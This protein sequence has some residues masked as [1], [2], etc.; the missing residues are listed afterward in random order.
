M[1]KMLLVGCNGRM[2][3]VITELAAG[4]ADIEITAGVDVAGEC[5]GKYPVVSSFDEVAADVDVIVDFSS[6][7][8]FDKMLDYALGKKLPVVICTTGLSET[9]IARLDEA[10]KEIAVLRSA[11]MS[12]GINLLDC[13]EKEADR[14]SGWMIWKT[15]IGSGRIRRLSAS[16]STRCSWRT[17]E[18]CAQGTASLILA[19]ETV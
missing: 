5:A 3:K 8:V 7:V 10:S 14:C 15:A 1:T 9:Q 17:S 11:N 2:G 18:S 12:L 16:A 19:P 4:D 13:S 6:P